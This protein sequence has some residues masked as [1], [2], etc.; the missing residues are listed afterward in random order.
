MKLNSLCLKTDLIF[1]KFDGEVIDREKYLVVKCNSNPNFFWGNLL[2]FNNAPKLGDFNNWKKIFKQEFTD[3]RIYHQTFA[4]DEEEMGDVSEFLDE[5]FELE[6]SVV[7]VAD[8]NQIKLPAK[9]HKSVVVTPL[10]NI[11]DWKTV[12][13]LQTATNPQYGNFYKKQ[14]TTYQ[15]MIE[16]NLGQWFGAYLDGMLVGSLGIFTEGNIGRFQIVS[17][18][19]KYQRLGICKALVFKASEYAFKK[20]GVETLVMVA[21]AEYHAA[22]VYESVGFVPKEKVYGVS[23]S[24][25][26]E[27]WIKMIE[28]E[29]GKIRENDLYPKLENWVDEVNPKM[30]LDLGCGQGICCDKINL[31]NR[32]YYGVDI[33]SILIKRANELYG[34]PNRKFILKNVTELPFDNNFFDAVFSIAVLHLLENPTAFYKEMGR[35][36]KTNGHFFILTADSEFENEWKKLETPEEKLY[37][38]SEQEISCEMKKYGLTVVKSERFRNFLLVIGVK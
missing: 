19:P 14:A 21:D 5:G 16:K 38:Y 8:K 4:W 22:K 36:L 28:G 26:D 3:P 18:H 20:M 24:N 11:D 23:R 32:E 7:L 27:Q 2:I 37:F 9:S 30:I 15:K 29:Q 10:K 35:V 33:S 6:K 25:K 13:E 34:N 12:I 17:T 31:N 1:I